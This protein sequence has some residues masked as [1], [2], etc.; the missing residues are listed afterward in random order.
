MSI[1]VTVGKDRREQFFSAIAMMRLVAVEAGKVAAFRDLANWHPHLQ[2]MANEAI[3]Y[4][5][6]FF[7]EICKCLYQYETNNEISVRD[8]YR[9]CLKLA[10]DFGAIRYV[11]EYLDAKEKII[12]L[13]SDDFELRN[14]YQLVQGYKATWH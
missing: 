3:D 8:Y 9:A 10:E 6:G 12:K 11:L 4:Y 2:G 13:G 14:P 5:D 1:K 7:P